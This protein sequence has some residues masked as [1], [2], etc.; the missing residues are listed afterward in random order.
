MPV[1]NIGV[2]NNNTT[3]NGNISRIGTELVFVPKTTG[4]ELD[5]P[6]YRT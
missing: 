6:M 4:T 5:M 2:G 3:Y 1:A